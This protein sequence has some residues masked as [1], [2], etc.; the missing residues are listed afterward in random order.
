MY[1]NYLVGTVRDLGGVRTPHDERL[2]KEATLAVVA[3]TMTLPT[4]LFDVE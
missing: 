1:S 3:V 2:I 4:S